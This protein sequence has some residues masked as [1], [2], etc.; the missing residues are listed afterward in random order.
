[1]SGQSQS[2]SFAEI[3][4]RNLPQPKKSLETTTD[5]WSS[6]GKNGKVITFKPKPVRLVLEAEDKDKP[7]KLLLFRDMVNKTAK[8]L[9]FKGLFALSTTRSGKG[10]L[11]F[12][13]ANREARDFAYQSIEAL[14]K[15][16]GFRK[17]LED[18]SWY[19]V[20]VHGV[21]VFPT[22]RTTP[23]RAKS[24]FAAASPKSDLLALVC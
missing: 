12:Q 4:R 8:D 2:P 24:L 13:L 1:M 11:V 9:G 16:I 15:T 19:K 10:N 3:A 20:V 5:G 14:R 23:L 22:V 7:I 6:I 18:D 21:E 17:I